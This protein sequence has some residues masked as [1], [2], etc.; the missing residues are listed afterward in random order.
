LEYIMNAIY[1]AERFV[2]GL[3]AVTIVTLLSL[4]FV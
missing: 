2:Q 3:L 1:L 4:V